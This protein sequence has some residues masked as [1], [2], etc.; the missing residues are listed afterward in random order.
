LSDLLPVHGFVLAGGKSSRMG[1]DKATLP[2]HGRPMVEIAVEKLRG[3]CAEVSIVGNRNDLESY[4][5][6]VQEERLDAGPAAGI[7]AGLKFARQEWA[8][9]IPVDVPLVPETLLRLWCEEA[10]RVEMTVS[11][12][13]VM[14]KQ[15]AFCMLKRERLASVTHLLNDGE[16]RLEILLN[17]A[18]SA[19]NCASW[20]YDELDLYSYPDYQG[21]DTETLNRWFS[22]VNSPADLVEAEAWAELST[23]FRPGGS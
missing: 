13:G 14:Q 21:P 1:V 11:Y 19:D 18:A 5:S 6:V 9:F 23:P 3:F 8:M 15:P 7:E 16:R 2:F 4:G 20:M 10:L 12:L 17:L 22:N